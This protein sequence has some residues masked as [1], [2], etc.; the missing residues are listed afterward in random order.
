MRC[1]TMD[2]SESF[3]VQAA[4]LLETANDVQFAPRR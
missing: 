1:S 4:Q 2:G 3:R